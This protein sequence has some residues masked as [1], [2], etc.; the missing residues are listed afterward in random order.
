MRAFF[1]CFLIVVFLPVSNALAQRGDSRSRTINQR[2]APNWTSD[3]EFTFTERAADGTEIT[4]VVNAATGEITSLEQ[5]SGEADPAV[6]R[7]GQLPRSES[8]ATDTNIEFI[9]ESDE[10][11]NLFWIDMAGRQVQYGS[12]APGERRSQHTYAGHVWMAQSPEGRFYGS[13]IAQSPASSVRIKESYEAPK[14][15]AQD[16]R[17]TYRSRRGGPNRSQDGRGPIERSAGGLR[18]H[19]QDDSQENWIELDFGEPDQRDIV[20][21]SWSPDGSVVAAWK[22]QFHEPADAVTIESS[23]SSGGRANVKRNPYRLPGDPYDEFELFVFD[24]NTGQR[25]TTDLPTIDF[26]YPRIHWFDNNKLAISKI[27]RGHQRV[28]LFVIDPAEQTTLTLVDEQSDTFIWTMHGPRVPLFT[29]LENTDEVIYSSESSGYR[30]LYLLDLK[31]ASTLS[32]REGGAE[33]DAL[34]AITSGDW[35][36]R[37]IVEIDEEHRTLDLLVGEFYDDQ[38]PYHR[39]LLRVSFDGEEMIVITESDGDHTVQFSP[40]RDYV[41]VTHSRVDSPPTHELRRTRDGTLVAELMRAERIGDEESD[42]TLPR[43]FHSAGRDGETE[44]WGNLYFP[45]NFDPSK[46]KYYPVIEAIYAGPHDSHVP[47]R[48]LHSRRF[49]DLTSLGFVVVQIDGMGTAN[50]SKTF[51]D[52]CW[53]NVKDAGFPDRIAWMKAAAQQYPAIDLSRVGVFGTSAGG[54]NACGALLF[55]GD[56]YQ[57]AYASCGCHDNRMDKASWNEQWMGYP[58]ADHYATNSNIDNADR[59]Q[60]D[61]FLVVGELDSNVPPESTYRLVD[62]LIKADKDFDF[63]MIPGMGHSDGGGY[64]RRRMREFFVEKLQP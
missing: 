44:I 58:V 4:R 15:A 9:N 45:A 30:H 18:I 10:R 37:E 31:S 1:V 26:G 61:L 39:H 22:V 64:G 3:T 62:A 35:L 63:L 36:V 48:Y 6:L 43:V 20:S 53:H 32:A 25:I 7:G 42:W 56:F 40:T 50:R 23:P 13:T 8:S 21:Q 16:G 11:V 28:R 29:F 46:T 38:D 33:V 41:I 27:D 19:A 55:H 24:A 54:Q 60:G 17:R 51:H 34:K 59:L 47:K 52:Q 12:L 2:I 5:P 49:N 57:A 14:R